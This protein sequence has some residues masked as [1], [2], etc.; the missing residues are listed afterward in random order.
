MDTRKNRLEK[1]RKKRRI[2]RNRKIGRAVVKGLKYI[3]VS[4]VQYLFIHNSNTFNGYLDKIA[5]FIN[6]IRFYHQDRSIKC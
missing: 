2:A 1:A 5:D 6:S 3:P 4:W